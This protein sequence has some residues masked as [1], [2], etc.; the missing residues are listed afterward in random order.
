M[1]EHECEAEPAEAG[2]AA[3]GGTSRDQA[4]AACRGEIGGILKT[5]GVAGS[6]AVLTLDLTLA[7]M[8]CLMVLNRRPEP[9]TV[10]RLAAT[11]KVSE[12]TASQL[13]ERLVQ[14][15][16]AERAPDPRDRRRTLVSLSDEA[17]GKMDSVRD[18]S[19]Q[20]VHQALASLGDD[21]LE[22][23]RMGL[24]ALAAACAVLTATGTRQPA[25]AERGDE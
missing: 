9:Q 11:L 1:N 13:V 8:R 23:L 16:L 4:I 18:E 20:T 7:Q 21:E 5:I 22:A 14:R 17:R 25:P 3:S 6:A 2:P 19:E 24:R 12:P 15:G 10:G